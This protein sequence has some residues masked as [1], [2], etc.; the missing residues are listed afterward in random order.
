LLDAGKPFGLRPCGLG[1]RDSTR[2]EAG[3][4]LYGHELAGPFDLTPGDAGFASFVKLYKPF[5]IGRKAYMAREAK[6]T[7][8]V[9]RFRI[10]EKGVRLPKLG[11]A[12]VDRRG[13]VIGYVTSCAM[14]S[15]GLLT[16][17]A[18][19]ERSHQAEG[20]SIGIIVGSGS[21]PERPK[22]GD[23]LTVPIPAQV[24]SRFMSR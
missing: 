22:I 4:P 24:V 8:E 6:R 12:V 14:D 13:R 10:S 15:E 18:W 20:T 3:L 21:L 9:V 5:F 16:G 1:A 19:I 2:T 11:D 7:M 23:R 17:M